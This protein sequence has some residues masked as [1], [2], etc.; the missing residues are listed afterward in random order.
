MEVAL[1][2]A[3]DCL[4][5]QGRLGHKT[6]HLRRYS[7]P[8]TL[9]I[10]HPTACRL[11]QFSPFHSSPVQSSD[12]RRQSQLE[13][14]VLFSLSGQSSLIQIVK[15]WSLKDWRVWTYLAELAGCGCCLTPTKGYGST[16]G[17][18]ERCHC[19]GGVASILLLRGAYW[20]L[21]VMTQK[22]KVRYC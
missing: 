20:R 10:E 22:H 15:T 11:V 16:R 17:G 9:S 7:S 21:H 12:C 14:P 3:N 2:L 4:D 19:F 5:K 1:R 18:V 13:R 8:Q 6:K